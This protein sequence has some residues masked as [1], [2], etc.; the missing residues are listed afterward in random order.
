MSELFFAW[1]VRVMDCSCCHEVK[2]NFHLLSSVISLCS[3][4]KGSKINLESADRCKRNGI[5]Q[6][7]YEI[8]SVRTSMS[9]KQWPS[10]CESRLLFLRPFPFSDWII[11]AT[12]HCWSKEKEILLS[13]LG[14]TLKFIKC[15]QY[16]K[17]LRPSNDWEVSKFQNFPAGPDFRTYFY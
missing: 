17:I 9:E 7:R 12:I 4:Q 13:C 11:T 16:M 6:L 15:K 3:T 1:K 14:G 8:K 5:I 2:A 10:I